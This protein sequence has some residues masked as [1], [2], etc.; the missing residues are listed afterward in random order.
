MADHEPVAQ[1]RDQLLERKQV[2]AATNV[3][4]RQIILHSCHRIVWCRAGSERHRASPQEPLAKRKDDRWPSC[5]I[6]RSR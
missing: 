4:R 5:T 2:G 3:D 6:C 1:R